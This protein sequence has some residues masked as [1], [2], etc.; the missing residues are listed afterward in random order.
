[1]G[2]PEECPI[3]TCECEGQLRVNDDCSE[4]KFCNSATETD[5]EK[6]SC[7]G[8]DSFPIVTVNL[9]THNWY[10]GNDTGRCPGAFHVGCQADPHITT[11]PDGSSSSSLVASITLITILPFLASMVIY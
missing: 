2:G 10:C 6:I 11:T 8:N 9:A 7:K 4:A 1:M 5:A 3:G